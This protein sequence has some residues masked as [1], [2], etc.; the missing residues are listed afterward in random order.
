LLKLFPVQK[1]RTID[2]KTLSQWR[3]HHLNRDDCF[4]VENL[5]IVVFSGVQPTE[6]HITEDAQAL[7]KDWDSKIKY[8][9]DLQ[10]R[11]GPCYA[12]KGVLYTIWKVYEDRQ[13]AFV[14]SIWPA[15]EE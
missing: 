12:E 2:A 14:Q 5:E 1:N 13:L 7:F 9:R 8:E 6:I 4:H 3:T 15:G 10:L 11:N